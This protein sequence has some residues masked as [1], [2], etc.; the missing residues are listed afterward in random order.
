MIFLKARKLFF[1]S[2]I[3]L[4]CATSV[5]AVPHL[6]ADV[7][8]V[9]IPHLPPGGDLVNPIRFAGIRQAASSLGARGG[10]AWEAKN[11][12]A[13]LDKEAVFLDQVFDF[14]QLLLGHNVLP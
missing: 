7:G 1:S 10:L 12:D 13:E 9:K 14:N 4:S 11:V 2:V 3:T 8:Y 5:F 6:T